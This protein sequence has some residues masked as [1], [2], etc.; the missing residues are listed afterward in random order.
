MLKSIIEASGVISFVVMVVAIFLM[1]VGFGLHMLGVVAFAAM[2]A[3]S[4]K[5]FGVLII[6]FAVFVVALMAD[7]IDEAIV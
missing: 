7:A 1:A 3:F 4:T 6:A 2:A 5:C